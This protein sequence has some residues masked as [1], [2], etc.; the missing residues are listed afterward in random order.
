M[1][2]YPFQPKYIQVKEEILEKIRKKIFP[3]S[4][5]LPPEGELVKIFKVSRNTV[6]TAVKSLREEGIVSSS[7]GKQSR[8]DEEKIPAEKKLGHLAWL[9]TEYIGNEGVYFEIFK[10]MTHCAAER[11]LSLDYINLSF[12]SSDGNFVRNIGSY[13]GIIITGRIVR[14]KISDELFELLSSMENVVAI[15]SVNGLP[16]RLIIGTD[17]RKGSETAVRYLA[18]RG[19]KKVAFLGISPSFY[20]YQPFA[21]RLEGYRDAVKKYSLN[22]DKDLAI[23]SDEIKN[24]YDV[25]PIIRNVLK[26]HPDVD[27]FLTVTD[28]IAFQTL[29]AL[30][31]MDI[32][33]PFDISLVGF[34]GLSAGEYVSPRLTTIAHPFAA[35]ADTVIKN[36]LKKNFPK[37]LKFIPVKPS[38]IIRET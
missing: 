28:F 2:K 25:K 8:I 20:S 6:R 16:A 33:V 26:K 14:N 24:F 23:I 9:D 22:S 31:S 7:Q 37:K 17:N 38:L 13:T 1:K 10:H 36:I 3:D 32:K 11:G 15:D 35:I 34:D 21:E 5:F 29:Y 30:K 12:E 19:R 27:A 18:E 4:S